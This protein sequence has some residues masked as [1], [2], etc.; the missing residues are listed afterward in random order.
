MW[1]GKSGSV[2]LRP[3]VSVTS[4]EVPTL[5]AVIHDCEGLTDEAFEAL[6]DAATRRVVRSLK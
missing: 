5:T 1:P 4:I 2:G 3:F 6:V